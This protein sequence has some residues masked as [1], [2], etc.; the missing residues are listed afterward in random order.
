LY[1]T[2]PYC[3]SKDVSAPSICAE[4]GIGPLKVKSVIMVV[5]A[6][7][8]RVGNGPFAGEVSVEEA[9]KVGMQEYGTVTGRPRRT[10]PSLIWEELKL[11]AQVNSASCIAL[12]KLDV[13]FPSCA[14]KRKFDELPEDAKAFVKEVEER[15]GVPVGLIGT[16]ADAKDIIDRREEIGI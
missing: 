6:Y 1:G 8:T 10:N 11:S 5:K 13:K 15:V 3:T 9:E 14:G 12:T 2:Y 7:T 4:I 16:G